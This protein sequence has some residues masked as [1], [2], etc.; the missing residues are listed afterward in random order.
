MGDVHERNTGARGKIV[1]GYPRTIDIDRQVD[2]RRSVGFFMRRDAQSGNSLLD[3]P[4][5]AEVVELPLA[6]NAGQLIL[7]PVEV[8]GATGIF[9]QF[10]FN[11]LGGLG[12]RARHLDGIDFLD[13]RMLARGAFIEVSLPLRRLLNDIGEKGGG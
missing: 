8:K 7:N 4:L 5:V 6:G 9:A 1:G 10:F 3:E 12:S 11:S 13:W 2:E